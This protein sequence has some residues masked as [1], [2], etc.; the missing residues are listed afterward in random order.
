MALIRPHCG[1]QTYTYGAGTLVMYVSWQGFQYFH[2]SSMKR[3]IIKP[4]EFDNQMLDE[5]DDDKLLQYL[6]RCECLGKD[7]AA[8]SI[9]A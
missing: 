6:E 8:V 5:V 9:I 1:A 4:I 7:N 2:S 3:E